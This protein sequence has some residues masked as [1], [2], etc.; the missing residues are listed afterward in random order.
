MKKLLLTLLVLSNLLFLL[1]KDKPPSALQL[2]A[3]AW[4]PVVITAYGQ[5]GAS[6]LVPDMVT[7]QF[8]LFLSRSKI[9]QMQA[10]I[11]PLQHREYIDEAWDCDD[12]AKEW[13]VL[14]HRWTIDNVS[15][16]LPIA[17]AAFVCYVEIHPGAFDGSWSEEGAHALGLICDD[18]GVWWFVE[19]MSGAVVKAQEALFEGTIEARK[20]IW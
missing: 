14:A 1:G 6:P 5:T 20:I 4:P 10:A 2:T 7:D 13:A 12:M 15:G 16:K 3:S 19:C 8:F 18:G 17:L 11:R 9:N